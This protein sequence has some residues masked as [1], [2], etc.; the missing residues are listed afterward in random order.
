[1]T[2]DQALLFLGVKYVKYKEEITLE[3]IPE[4]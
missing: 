4:S 1:M 2:M 3:L